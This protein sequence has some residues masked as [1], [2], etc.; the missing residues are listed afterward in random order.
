MINVAGLGSAGSY[1]LR[2]LDQEGFEYQG[3]DPK[4]PDY[5]I[6]CGY[7]TNLDR[8][9]VFANRSGLE[10]E[11][12]AP[13]RSRNVTFSG[14]GFNPVSFP[15]KGI[16]TF[17][18]N[19]FEADLING[20]RFVR[21]TLG[22][23][24]EAEIFIDATGV[25][26]Q[27]LGRAEGDR[28]LYAKE[29]LA[30]SAKHDDFYFYFFSNGSGY[31]WEFPLENGYHVG[32][33]ALSLDTVNEALLSV[34]SGKVAGRKIRMKP[35][36][37]NISSGNTIGVG[38]SIGLVSPLTGE[39]I[40]PALESAEMLIQSLKKHDDLSTIT[41]DYRHQIMKKYGYYEQLYELVSAIQSQR[42]LKVSSLRSALFARKDLLGFGIGFSIRKVIGHFL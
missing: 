33:G 34:K 35:L 39:G 37:D 28:L 9:K 41:N 19:H 25:S 14:N 23:K 24:D 4:R 27:L 3:F 29:F 26:R 12:Y 6:P 8:I 22:K 1:L 40:I 21:K 36:F 42:A 30:D 2:R 5:Y 17:D 15:G 38:E 31:Y 7:A 13:V 11:D 18:K 16:G 32:A 10:I 20:L